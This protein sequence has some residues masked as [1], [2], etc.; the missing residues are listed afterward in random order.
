[1]WQSYRT[2]KQ[3]LGWIYRNLRIC[4][5][6]DCMS[7]IQRSKETAWKVLLPSNHWNPWTSISILTQETVY[8]KRFN[9]LYPLFLFFCEWN[10]T[11][12]I[13]FKGSAY[14]AAFSFPQFYQNVCRGRERSSQILCRISRP[15]RFFNDSIGWP[16]TRTT[17]EILRFKVKNELAYIIALAFAYWIFLF[18]DRTNL[19][20]L[21]RAP[22]TLWKFNYVRA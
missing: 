18:F 8:I 12:S 4:I 21:L 22:F 13:Q 3:H 15:E 7:G 2:Q 9:I 20:Q 5:R 17:H 16:D 10:Q 6:A 19:Q 14:G 1:M 11:T